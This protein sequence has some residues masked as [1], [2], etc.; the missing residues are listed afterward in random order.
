MGAGRGLPG[1]LAAG[2]AGG[3]AGAERGSAAD[4]SDR[5]GGTGSGGGAC[6]ISGGAGGT[7]PDAGGTPCPSAQT[8]VHR[9]GGNAEPDCA[10][11]G[12]C[13]SEQPASARRFVPQRKQ[14]ITR[15]QHHRGDVCRQLRQSVGQ[16]NEACRYAA[17]LGRW[18]CECRY[19]RIV[20]RYEDHRPVL[21]VGQRLSG[22]RPKCS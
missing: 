12:V 9:Y 20:S 19:G 16:G 11:G 6:H 10:G 8:L 22:H 7:G 3:S 4:L 2:A 17:P 5:P 15:R 18:Q 13:I 14:H 21:V 1:Y